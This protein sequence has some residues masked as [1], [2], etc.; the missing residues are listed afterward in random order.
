MER[1]EANIRW[2]AKLIGENEGK[3][4]IYWMNQFGVASGLRTQTVADYI[5]TLIMSRVVLNR[6]GRLYVQARTEA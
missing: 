6:G 2:L 1:R 4:I 3:P 5:K